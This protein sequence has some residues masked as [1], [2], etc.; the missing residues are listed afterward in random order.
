MSASES[1]TPPATVN[2]E[3]PPAE[4]M[5]ATT[6]EATAATPRSA[7]IIRALIFDF[8]K[9]GRSRFRT[10]HTRFIAACI[11][12]M[13]PRPPHRVPAMPT[14]RLSPLPES[15]WT[16]DRIWSPITG[17]CARAEWRTESCRSEFPWSTN[18]RT[19]TMTSSSGNS[20][21]NP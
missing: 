2:G 20:E 11:A 12:F 18:P 21:K 14:A 19:V 3:C 9:F 13:T 15:E 17:N 8:Q 10:S 4:T 7:S 5:P 6:A 1:T 16:F